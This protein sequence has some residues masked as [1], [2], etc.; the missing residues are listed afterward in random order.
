MDQLL[1]LDEEGRNSGELL[2]RFWDD[3]PY[4]IGV[5]SGWMT[6]A[7]TKKHDMFVLATDAW[8]SSKLRQDDPMM[9]CT[10]FSNHACA[11]TLSMAIR[12]L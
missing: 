8:L 12:T 7:T 1:F 5:R 11:R 10:T 9:V 6:H 2:H 3:T 4:L